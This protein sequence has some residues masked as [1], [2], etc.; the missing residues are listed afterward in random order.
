VKHYFSAYEAGLYAAVNLTGK[1]VLFLGS[2]VPAVILPKAVSKRL[3]GENSAALL[4]QAVGVTI[5]LSGSAL[6]LFS[7][8]PGPIVRIFAGHQFVAAAPYVMQ[9]DAA[10]CL[11]A[12]VTLAVNYRIGIHQFYFLPWLGAV[13][14]CE[15]IAIVL[16]HQ[17]LWE[18]IHVLLI[19][20]GV[21]SALCLWGPNGA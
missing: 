5:L 1:V 19:G 9:Y 13:L 18:V 20:N 2:F 8:M 12:L 6:V 10:M 11:L 4:A 3:R 17:S 21:A 7:A 15:I 16:W 14:A